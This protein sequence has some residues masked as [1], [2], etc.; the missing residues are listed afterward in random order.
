MK[1]WKKVWLAIG[2]VA[3]GCRNI[4]FTIQQSRKGVV[5]GSDG[6]SLRVRN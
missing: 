4:F 1:T 5:D 2:G 6:Q 3:S